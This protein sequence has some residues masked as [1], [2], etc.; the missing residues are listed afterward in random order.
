MKDKVLI[1]VAASFVAASV[2]AWMLLYTPKTPAA[3]DTKSSSANTSIE[4]AVA[5]I[6]YGDE[7]FSPTQLSVKSGQTIHIH[8]NSKLS[9]EFASG[10]HPDHS[11]NPELNMPEIEPGGDTSFKV[12]RVGVWAFHNHFAH[13]HTGTL[14]VTE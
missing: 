8:N 12:T 5:T 10:N 2:V 4:K 7:G 9:L 14:T 6:T 11:L 3:N 1:G 13:D